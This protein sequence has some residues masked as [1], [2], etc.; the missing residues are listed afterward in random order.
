MKRPVLGSLIAT[1]VSL[2]AA[3]AAAGVKVG[4]ELPPEPGKYLVSVAAARE[5]DPSKLV[6]TFVAGEIFTVERGQNRFAVEWNGL[7][8]NHMP[9]PAGRYAIHAV[10]APARLWPVD[11]NYHAFTAK[12]AGG[13][14]DLLPDPAEPEL[15][16]KTVPV[17]GD[18]VNS[19]LLD[20][21]TAED[22]RGT[23]GFQYMENGRSCPLVVFNGA[24][25]PR[26]KISFRGSWPSGGAGTTTTVATDG[27]T[28][29]GMSC[30][31]ST[32]FIFRPDGKRF[33][34][35]DAKYRRGVHLAKGKVTDLAA[36]KR[37]D[38]TSV[39]A[40]TETGV[41]S[42]VPSARGRMRTVVST[43]EFVNAIT[44]LAGA[45]GAPLGQVKVRG[46][47]TMKCRGGRLYVLYRPA[48]GAFAVGAFALAQGLPTGELRKLVDVRG[49][50]PGDIAVDS[51]GR[52]FVSDPAGNRVYRYGADGKPDLKFGRLEAQVSGAYDPETMMNPWSIAAWRDAKGRDRLL[53]VERD[54]PN[55]TS[56]WDASTGAYL[57]EYASY[58]LRCNTGYMIDP[59][60]PSHVYMPAFGN[61]LV[62]YLLDY[63]KGAWKTDAV[64]PD[65]SAG[66]RAD[67]EKPV[68]VRRGG[69]LYFASERNGWI[70]RLTDD[71]KRVVR[72]AAMFRDGPNGAFWHD[73][74]GNGAVDE[75]EKTPMKLPGNVFTYH[76]QTFLSDLSYLGMGQNSRCLYRAAPSSFDRHGNPVFT[77]WETVLEDPVFLAR[78]KGRPSALDGGNELDNRFSSP[79][80]KADG[81]VGGSLYVHARGGRDF[82]ANAGA[83]YKI[84]RYD[85]DGK[86]GYKLA[87][88]VGRAA[89]ADRKKADLL[90]GMRLFKPVNGLFAVVDQSRSGVQVYTDSGI[91]LD[92]LF[93]PGESS[94]PQGVYR[95]PG[96]FF[97]GTVLPNRENGKVY[98]A[99]GKFTPFVYE[100]EGWTMTENP[101][102]PVPRF[103]KTVQL[104]DKDIADPPE[105]ALTLRGGVGKARFCSFA[106]AV[107]G[108]SVEGASEAGWESA[109][110]VS[111]TD[112]AGTAKVAVKT[113]W[114]PKGLFLRWHVRKPEALVWRKRPAPERLFTHDVEADTVGFYFHGDADA[115]FTFG[116]FTDEKGELKP[117]G[118]G[119]YEEKP[120]LQK[121]NARRQSY[122][123]PVGEASFAHVGPIA[124]AK[125]GFAKDADGKGFALAVAI[126]RAALPFASA[127]SAKLSPDFRTR[128]NFDANLGGHNRFWWANTDGSANTVTYDEPS[129]A[130]IYPGSWAQ[131]RF[132]GFADGL[133]LRDWM[134][135]GPFGGPGSEKI[136]RNVWDKPNV[137]EFFRSRKYAPDGDRYDPRKTYGGPETA[138]WWPA[139]R[140]AVRWTPATM[141]ELDNRVFISNQG[142]QVWYGVTFITAPAPVEVTLKFYTL[143]QAYVDWTLNGEPLA[144]TF[145]QYRP[146]PRKSHRLVAETKVTLKKGVNELRFRG[147]AGGYIPFLV[148]A[149]VH[150]P[151]E[152][153]W[154]LGTGIPR[155]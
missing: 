96:E 59:E 154:Q 44:L 29:W 131:A 23:F 153:L 150:A 49:F 62:R 134:K 9:V 119:F 136:Q 11:G 39:V 6:A 30:D 100:I 107:G 86:G 37:P 71:G 118:V 128:V 67:L 144:P 20:V 25:L 102:R 104:E 66:M 111:F 94:R 51:R 139:P 124:G 56:E 126:P 147:S 151:E 90:G 132:T 18:P 46:P 106:P 91:Y 122:K 7:D 48:G 63:E 38:G 113:L 149:E 34:R 32:D 77:Q 82:N 145:A 42:R 12:Y 88:R 133:V 76:G 83:Q 117:L 58:Q 72:S 65:V 60:K 146:D 74:N 61:W 41:M 141:R 127:K 5:D 79:W 143:S 53:V 109:P 57:G 68:A 135:L 31:G 52:L 125:Y 17:E 45:D 15:W 55:R 19:P 120:A 95:Q 3:L 54:G 43:N 115:R 73:A 108:V 89:L 105:I 92:T 138:G 50:T 87:W 110:E 47:L 13:V 27:E 40:F 112:L 152:T 36:W 114:S 93:A 33:G 28:V 4:I 155:P 129:E 14:G 148:G 22:G 130:R 140:A 98:Y 80:M 70:Y 116:L 10:Y 8:D 121:V 35:D 2:S 142:A 78:A 69:R 75:D 84:T 64:F 26:E 85:P 1:S 81:D 137:R 24:E 123:T 101:V 16:L 97:C 99:A 21:D 103:K